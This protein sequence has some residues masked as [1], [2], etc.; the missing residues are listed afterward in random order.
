MPDSSDAQTLELKLKK[1]F[2]DAPL[3]LRIVMFFVPHKIACNPKTGRVIVVKTFR[4][5]LFQYAPEEFGLC[6][7]GACC[8]VRMRAEHVSFMNGGPT[9]GNPTVFLK[10]GDA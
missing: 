9:P 5:S 8:L 6:N 3:W 4:D 1:H 2:T 10:P 7:C